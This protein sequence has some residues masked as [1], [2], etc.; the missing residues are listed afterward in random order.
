MILKKFPSEFK[1]SKINHNSDFEF[2]DEKI[3]LV[4]IVNKKFFS[5]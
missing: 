1:S 5:S 4:V 3:K 2:L